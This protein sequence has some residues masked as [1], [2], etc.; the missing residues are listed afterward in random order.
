M[1][2]EMFLVAIFVSLAAVSAACVAGAFYQHKR[3]E[4][5][6]KAKAAKALR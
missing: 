2:A 4:A 5:G 3:R 6:R 1:T